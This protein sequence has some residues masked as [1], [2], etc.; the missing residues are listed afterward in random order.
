MRLLSLSYVTP[1]KGL[2][3]LAKW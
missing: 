3:D 1:G 2:A